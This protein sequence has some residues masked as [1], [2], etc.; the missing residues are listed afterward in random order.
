[1]AKSRRH[2]LLSGRVQGVGFRHFVHQKAK[3]CQLNGWVKNLPNGKV[4]LEVEGREKDLNCFIDYLK[5][6]NGYSR[7]DQLNQSKL[8]PNANYSDFSIRY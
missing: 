6:G 1:M 4:E 7:T 5:L 3:E 8:E 2:I